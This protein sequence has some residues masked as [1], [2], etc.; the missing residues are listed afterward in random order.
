MDNLH[1]KTV[2]LRY[3]NLEMMVPYSGVDPDVT[4]RHPDQILRALMLK[5]VDVRNLVRNEQGALIREC[6]KAVGNDALLREFL[7]YCYERCSAPRGH[8]ASAEWESIR[9][10]LSMRG[11]YLPAEVS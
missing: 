1:E 6:I 2:L 4:I 10:L 5:G 11:I 8:G 9:G 3:G 7:T